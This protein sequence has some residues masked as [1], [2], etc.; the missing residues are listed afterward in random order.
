MTKIA[1]LAYKTLN[2]GDEIQSIATKRLVES[3]G[4]SVD[5][6]ID[7]EELKD[8]RSP[9][10]VKLICNGWF[11]EKPEN[12]PPADCIE[13]LFI[14]MHIS[15]E[16]DSIKHLAAKSLHAYYEK[17]GPIG[18]RDYHTLRVL[19]EAGIPAYFSGCMTLTLQKYS[20]NRTQ[21]IVFSDPFYRLRPNKYEKYMAKKLIVKHERDKIVWVKHRRES[22]DICQLERDKSTEE[23]LNLYARA[24]LVIT[25]RMHTALTCFAF[26]TPV[27]FIDAGYEG[28][29]SRNRFEG[30]I[31][32]VPRI[33]EDSLPFARKTASHFIA[34]LLNFHKPFAS[35][36][37][38]NINSEFPV[39]SSAN[40]NT[41]AQEIIRRVSRFIS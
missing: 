25:S 39:S 2:I 22:R 37:N 40:T 21:E 13:P 29:N 16:F 32:N 41:L 23:I 31:D 8:F 18:C 11:M 20:A 24:K 26:G 33:T 5:L 9:D 28:V 14:S 27:Y 30:L 3:L 34:R 4:Y 19:V 38:F 17:Y 35:N 36:L 15:H 1:I 7:R 10:K 12:W 6:M